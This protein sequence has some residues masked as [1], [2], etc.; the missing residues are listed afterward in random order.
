LLSSQTTD[1]PGTTQT[2][3]Q[4]R[5]GA[6]FQS[7][8]IP[9]PNANPST[10]ISISKKTAP[11]QFQRPKEQPENG[12]DLGVF[13]RPVNSSSMSPPRRLRKQYTHPAPTANRARP[14]TDP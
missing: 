8:P 6:T 10:R 13:G 12:F 7:Y 11:T 3:V 4:D 2:L 5:S 14:P 1:T 9:H